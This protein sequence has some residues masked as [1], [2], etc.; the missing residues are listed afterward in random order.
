MVKMS[1]KRSN[2][3]R[4]ILLI[5]VFGIVG[6]FFVF[7]FLI[8][9]FSKSTDLQTILQNLPKELSQSINMASKQNGESDIIAKFEELAKEIRKSQADHS[10]QLDSQ[11]RMFEKKLQELKQAPTGA[12]LREKLA[13]IFP[14][15]PFVRFPA[16]IW[17]LK[18]DEPKDNTNGDTPDLYYNQ[19]RS[20][21]DK[22]PGFVHEVLNDEVMTTFVR[23][24]YSNIPEVIEAYETLPS[25]V[26][27]VDFFK[28]L[29]LLARGG[30]YADIDTDLLQPIPNWIPETITPNDVGLIVGVEHD[31]QYRDWKN[32]YV[33]RLQFGTWVIQ[34]KAGHPVLREIVA[35]ITQNT[36]KRKEEKDLNVNIRNDLNIMSWTGSGIFTDVIFGYFNN[37]L[38]TNINKQVTW[39]EFR[40]IRTPKILADILVFPTF[41]FNAP[42]KT[43]D[44]DLNKGLYFASHKAE[45][46]WKALPKVAE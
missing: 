6:L 8:N 10:R 40:G 46:S 20:W 41:S 32:L 33:R 45:K 1:K 4:K 38:K 22:N 34:A 36:L 43:T 15:D 11:R 14:Y 7:K 44:E 13:T 9:T 5:C 2:N 29:I 35:R 27:K 39:K 42:L 24:F 30:V 28:Y 17:Q 16:Y 37:P 18:K 31:A 23:H 21:D 19:I 12:T 26:L 3:I 25:P